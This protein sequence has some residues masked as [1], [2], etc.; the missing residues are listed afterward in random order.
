MSLHL[1]KT[2]AIKPIRT[3]DNYDMSD[4]E[5]LEDIEYCNEKLQVFK[6]SQFPLSVKII[7]TEENIGVNFAKPDQKCRF[8]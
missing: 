3:L 1:K 4:S 6:R 8:L 2:K 5:E 7:G